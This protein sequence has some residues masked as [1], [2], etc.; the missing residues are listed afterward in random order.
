MTK[1]GTKRIKPSLLQT[2][3]ECLGALKR[4]SGYA[5]VNLSYALDVLEKTFDD[6]NA[7]QQAESQAIAAAAA[8]RLKA[9]SKEWDFHVLVLGAKDQ[10]VAQFGRDSDEAAA[11]GLK[12][13]SE[14][15]TRARK[16]PTQS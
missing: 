1:N 11:V 13:K 7:A 4:L 3:K 6:L 14:Y 5:P 12:K 10:V 8:A 15:K 16:A 9:V 2:D